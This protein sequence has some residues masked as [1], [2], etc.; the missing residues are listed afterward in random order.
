MEEEEKEEE[1]DEDDDAEEGDDVVVDDVVADSFARKQRTTTSVQRRTKASFLTCPQEARSKI[2]ISHLAAI[3]DIFLLP[4]LA[5]GI[6]DES[7]QDGRRNGAKQPDDSEFDSQAERSLRFGNA[8]HH[9]VFGRWFVADVV[10]WELLLEPLITHQL[11]TFGNSPQ[12]TRRILQHET[13]VY[14]V[15]HLLFSVP[16]Y[17]I[18]II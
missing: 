2:V 14:Q 4:Y 1:K 15:S 17:V 7:E 13:A 12:P 3:C 9:H 8:P 18:S 16:I 5:G 6:D 10:K 11:L